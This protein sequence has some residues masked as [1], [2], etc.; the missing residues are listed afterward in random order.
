MTL[1]TKHFKELLTKELATLEKELATIGRKNPES[2]SGWEAVETDDETDHAEEG[3]TAEDIEQYEY[4][5]AEANQLEFQLKEVKN[6]LGKIDAG[7]YG[8]CEVCNKPIELDRLEAN[9]SARTCKT[10]MGN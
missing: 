9:P 3:D 4:N 8:M 2:P 7:T 6:A 10:H 1:D 5:S